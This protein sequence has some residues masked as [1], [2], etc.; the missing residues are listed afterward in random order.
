MT[1]FDFLKLAA[2]VWYI[3]YSVTKTHGPF[4]I[5]ERLREFRGGRWHG[6]G[7][8]IISVTY[9]PDAPLT[10]GLPPNSRVIGEDNP[11]DGLLD[12]IICLSIW[13][14]LALVLIGANVVT[15]AFAVA[16]VALWVHSFSGWR[17]NI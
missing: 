1:P 17:M 14:A 12:C 3:A 11:K 10:K 16:G 9:D 8:S 5:F 2:A 4:G 7:K 15:D 6:R 13:V